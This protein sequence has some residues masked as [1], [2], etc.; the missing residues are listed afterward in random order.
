MEADKIDLKGVQETLLMPL[1]GRAVETQKEKPLLVDREAV[2]IIKSIDYDFMQI[3]NKI[4]ALSRASW[5]ARSIYFDQKICDYLRE[6]P[7]GTIVN[8]GCGLDTTYERVHNGKAIW[9]ELDFPEVIR[10]RKLFI[11]ESSTRKFLPYSVFDSAW[12]SQ[13]GNKEN[14]LIMIAGVIYYFEESDVKKLLD[15]FKME[16]RKSTVIFDYSSTRGIQIANK[17]VIE[18]GGMDKA[19]YLKWGTNDIYEI[20]KWNTGIRVAETM[21]MFAEHRKRY[22][23]T[24]RLGMWIS[25]TLSVM[26]LAK[27]TL[28]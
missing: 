18:D 28:E 21:K 4:N 23:L 1:W 20:E 10:T 6:H 5:I 15:T 26:S 2:N 27:I 11:T 7:D 25:D 3:S 14:V 19:A 24:K 9:Y 12:Y 17:A 22:P 8:I 13:I 16:F